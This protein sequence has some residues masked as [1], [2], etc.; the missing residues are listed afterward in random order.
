[1]R[2]VP[3]GF[4]TDHILTATLQIPPLEFAQRDVHTALDQP[5]LARLQSLPGVAAAAVTTS[6]PLDE[7]F[8]I[9]VHLYGKGKP[10]VLALSWVSPEFLSVFRIPLLHGRFF[11]PRLD[12]PAVRQVC[13]VNHAF[14]EQFF[15]GQNPVGKH[16]FGGTSA[17][18]IGEI[19]DTH[20]AGAAKAAAPF[21][22]YSTS[23]LKLKGNMY[24]AAAMF[25]QV[26]VRSPLPPSALLPELRAALHAV[27]PGVDATDVAT[28]DELVAK[29][30]G[31]QIFAV[32]LLGIFALA[33]LAIALAGIYAVL[34]YAVSQRTREI[35][36]RMALGAERRQITAMV[37]RRAAGL[38]ALGIA[39]GL[40]LAWTASSL[41]ARYLFGVPP[42][43]PFTLAAAAVV[44]L[45][46]GLGAAWWPARRAA[47][48]SPLLALR[49][50]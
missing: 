50:E 12:T 34:A 8:L 16:L 29:S 47:S 13:V 30:M 38:L 24:N 40:A 26:A 19:A 36:V 14:A 4:A 25:R 1:L 7:E 10:A 15:P 43:D 18:V 5:L 46:A 22:L 31:D 27:A 37:L 49:S 32:R 23:Q 2:S 17:V 20:G 21:V 39:I 48:V 11:D 28:M 6:L 42:R 3:L 9:N 41:L 33:A 44:M 35:G 45:L